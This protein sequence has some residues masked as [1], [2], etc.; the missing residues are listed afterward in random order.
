[1]SPSSC[2]LVA[3][4][5][6]LLLLCC[7]SPSRAQSVD[8][9]VTTDVQ[10]CVGPFAGSPRV[11]QICAT[12]GFARCDSFALNVSVSVD[13]VET[14]S[15]E[16]ASPLTWT[17]PYPLGGGCLGV[18]GLS[19][20]DRQ[21]LTPTYVL[22]HPVVTVVCA[23]VTVS[24]MP[25]QTIE[26]GA[27]CSGRTCANCTTTPLCGWCSREADFLQRHAIDD[28]TTYEA[29]SSAGRCI[30]RGIGSQ[31]WCAT[32]ALTYSVDPT[33]CPVFVG[34]PP[35]PNPGQGGDPNAH[36][37]ES[38]LFHGSKALQAL[39]FLGLIV[40]AGLA[41]VGVLLWVRRRQA[42]KR[43]REGEEAV[44]GRAV[45]LR[46]NNSSSSPTDDEFER[47][48]AGLVRPSRVGLSESFTA[49]LTDGADSSEYVPPSATSVNAD[50]YAPVIASG[51]TQPD[52]L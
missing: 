8:P 29:Y 52:D 13:G 32:C 34:T 39:F 25:L 26:L 36:S 22:V 16:E 7:L 17:Y 12:V 40:L 27:D 42:S 50:G 38:G 18:V 4:F 43:R 5:S 45:E 1:M 2:L 37:S 23:G 6:P 15:A 48:G 3:L 28:W 21:V 47:G 10:R 35:D 33:A 41:G 24:T 31:P 20:T 30:G 14:F 51:A 44:Y 46:G 49:R 9:H 19:S 11:P